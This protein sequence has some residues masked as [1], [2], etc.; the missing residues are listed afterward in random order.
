M[1]ISKSSNLEQRL[2]EFCVLLAELIPELPQTRIGNY[3]ADHLV[4]SGFSPS[5]NYAEAQD[6]ESRHD[7]IHKLKVVLKELRESLVALKITY[8]LHLV[9][10]EVK[11]VAAIKETNELVS[12]FVASVR[13]A[14]SHSGPKSDS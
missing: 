8:R 2:I 6:A 7:F 11:V 12:I 14:R 3:I 5:F 13:T 4:R 1:A 9:K 10:S